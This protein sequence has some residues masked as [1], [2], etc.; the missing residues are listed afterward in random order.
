VTIFKNEG[1]IINEWIK[2]YI[3]EGVDKIFMIDNGSDD[4]YV[5]D[6]YDGLVEVVIDGARHQQVNLY[7]HYYLNKCKLYEW[8]LV[9]DLDEFIYSRNGY[10]T[11]KGYLHSLDD[12][13]S[14]IAI[15]WKM[16]GS[17]GFDTM[18]KPHPKNIIE[19]FTKRVNYD[20]KELPPA[21]IIKDNNKYSHNKSIVRT[22]HLNCLDIH[23]HN[24]S[25]Y[26]HITS[27]NNYGQ[28]HGPFSKIDEMI[29]SNSCLHLNHYAIQ[30]FEWFMKVKATRGAA[31]NAQHEN[32]RDEKYFKTYDENDIDDIE[33]KMK[34][35]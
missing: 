28:I 31:D 8:V 4:N 18:D 32:V 19:S 27:D 21:A 6:D 26:N 14:Q 11:I 34:V 12:S 30:S 5:L 16:F 22:K 15:P 33:L 17:S 9:C 7:N 25:S 29:L 3:S 13:I 20:K 1:C 10:K 35:I 24:T 23:T 2:H